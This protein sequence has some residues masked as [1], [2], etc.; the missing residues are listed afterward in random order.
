LRRW[1]SPLRRLRRFGG[2]VRFLTWLLV[3]QAR[4]GHAFTLKLRADAKALLGRPQEAVE[5]LDRAA[6]LSPDDAR[7]LR[8]R[9][10]LLRKLGRSAEAL[11]DLS[12]ADSLRPNDATTLKLRGD[13]R[14]VM[15]RLEDAL[16][17]SRPPPPCLAYQC[18]VAWQSWR[19]SLGKG[20]NQERIEGEEKERSFGLRSRCMR[21]R[22]H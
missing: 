9:G 18:C 12:R 13:V 16:S 2:C 15:G 19:G 20:K 5:D 11:Q 1:V 10:A 3:P 8:A 22:G 6:A 21:W 17:V 14:R 4:P 7:T